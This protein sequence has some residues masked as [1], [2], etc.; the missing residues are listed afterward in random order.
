VGPNIPA[1]SRAF[2]EQA[3]AASQ[4][5]PRLLYHLAITLVTSN[6][7]IGAAMLRVHDATHGQ[8]EI[9]YFLHPDHWGKGLATEAATLLLDFGFADVGLH[10]VFGTC[11]PR[12]TPSA[13]VMAKLGMVREGRLRETMHLRDG[14][15]DSDVYSL[16]VYEW[17]GRGLGRLSPP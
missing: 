11:D 10:R 6:Q 17:T 5:V 3:V 8:G 7:L 16:L 4:S 9:G 12:N 15:R 13:R 14:W 1:E 2:V